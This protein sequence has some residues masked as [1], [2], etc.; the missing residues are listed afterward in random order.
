M[1]EHDDYADAVESDLDDLQDQADRLKD[2][3]DETRE[4]WESKQRS[5]DVPGAE[6]PD[7][8]DE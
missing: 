3:I 4:D 5:P 2:D 6:P 7:E 8:S 1:S